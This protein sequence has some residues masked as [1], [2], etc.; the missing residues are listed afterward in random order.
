MVELFRAGGFVMYP[1]V[2]L[3]IITVAIGIERM[4]Y[5]RRARMDADAFMGVINGFLERNSLDDAYKHCASTTGPVAGI[6]KAG[7]KNQK[8]GRT[9]VIRS[10]EDAATLEIAKLERGILI[11]QTI[12]KIA[13]LIG[14]FG[15]VTGMINSFRAIGQTAGGGNPANVAMGISEALIATASGLVVAIPAYF[16]S[17]YFMDLVNKFMLDMQKSSIQFLDGLGDLEENI[18]E[19]TQRLDTMGGDYLE[20]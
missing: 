17:F 9:E 2:V 8:R 11:L 13:P 1:M 16:L 14:L 6:I 3:S 19:R 5:L 7:L 15:T 20:V 12:S 4:I 18:A 10:I